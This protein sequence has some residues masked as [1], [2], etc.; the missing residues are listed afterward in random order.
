MQ[1]LIATIFSQPAALDELAETAVRFVNLISLA[2]QRA[3]MLSLLRRGVYGYLLRSAAHQMPRHRAR[4]L[5]LLAY[6]PLPGGYAERVESYCNDRDAGVRFA[7]M[8]VQLS[9]A[10]ARFYDTL[11]TYR[12]R[13]SLPEIEQII[14]LLR[15]K[16]WQLD[17]M[18][19]SISGVDNLQALALELM[20]EMDDENLLPHI[21]SLLEHVND[22]IRRS[23]IELI[24]DRGYTLNE[25]NI[26]QYFRS[27]HPLSRRAILRICARVGYSHSAICPIVEA[28]DEEYYDKILTSYKSTMLCQY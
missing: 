11:A 14:A 16:G 27:L 25:K 3:L 1:G 13:I 4:A 10:P 15:V 22:S 9:A 6:L 8:L 24:I 26:K 12:D 18:S 7:A 2:D 21:S 19:M 5:S 23:A 28:G 20:R 17:Y